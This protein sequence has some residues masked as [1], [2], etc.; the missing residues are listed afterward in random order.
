MQRK[1]L[2][3]V[4]RTKGTRIRSVSIDLSKNTSKR[5]RSNFVRELGNESINHAFATMSG[6]QL[7]EIGLTPRRLISR[8]YTL[9]QLERKFTDDELMHGGL[10][11]K[12]LLT[13][14]M[15]QRELNTSIREM[16]EM[17]KK[18]SKRRK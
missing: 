17:K 12:H 16:I 13:Y 5:L 2:I 10:K 7:L 11:P 6:A 8:G 14:G 1:S 9:T 3:K 4:K 15:S 18:N